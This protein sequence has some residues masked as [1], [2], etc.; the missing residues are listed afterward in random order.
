[1]LINEKKPVIQVKD[2]SVTYF[3]GQENEVK[4]LKDANLDIYLGEFVIFFG[5]SGCGKSTLLYSVAGLETRAEG[6]ILVNNKDIS[7]LT[8]V[9]LEFYHQKA[10]GMI[11]QAFY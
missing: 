3:P 7:K 10:T 4:A 1:M 6:E 8:P 2:L 11:F 9:E 5:P